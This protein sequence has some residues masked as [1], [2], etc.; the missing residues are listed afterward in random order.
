MNNIINQESWLPAFKEEKDHIYIL[1]T[2]LNL[3]GAEKIVSD[4]LWA[5]FYQ[6]APHKVT[7]FV[8]YDKNQE[9]SIP[10]NVNIVR[11]NNKIENGEM[12]LKQV[13]FDGKPLV[14][15]LINDK[16]SHYL[17]SLGLNLHIVIHNDKKGWSNTEEVFNHPQVISLISVCKYVTKQL[18]EVTDKT[19]FTVRHQ[20]SYKHFQFNP[21]TRDT[22]RNHFKFKNDDIVIGMTGRI[23]LQKNYFLALDVIAHLSRKDPRYKLVIL[24]GFEQSNMPVYFD[25]LKKANTLN[26]QKNITLPGFKDNAVEWLN[27]FDI[28]LN[29]SHFEGLSMATQEFIMNGLQMVVSNVSGQSEIF[30]N[31]KQLHFFDIPESLNN[32][33]TKN[34]SIDLTSDDV[35]YDKS[36]ELYEYKKLVEHI[37]MLIEENHSKRVTMNDENKN[38]INHITYGSHNVWSLFNFIPNKQKNKEIKPAFLTSNL[39]LGGA[40]RSLVNL[41]SEMKDNDIHIPLILL[42][43]SNYT[44]FYKQIID[45]KIEHYLCHSHIDVFTIGS[46]LLKYI[47]ENEINRI[48]LWNVD[49]KVKL[50]L[51][52]LAGH[53]VDI[54]DVSPGDYCFNEMDNQIAFQEAIYFNKET[55]FENIKT[56]VSKFDNSHL[57]QDYKK[58]LKQDTVII[59][60]GV[61]VMPEYVKTL[62]G[63]D[64][65]FKFLVCG[66]ITESKHI[67]TILQAFRKL[68]EVNKNVCIDFYGSVEPYNIS[69]YEKLCSDYSD[70]IKNEVVKFKGNIDDPRSIMKDYHSIIILGTH[71]GSPNMVLES[72]SCK[73]PCITND[74]GGTKEVINNETG[75]LLPEKPD[76]MLLHEA[77]S[78]TVY[79]YKTVS[80]R[81]ESAYEHIMENFSMKLM[82]ER[83]LKVIYS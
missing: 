24:G 30:D 4:Q 7:L 52:K 69:Y 47:F 37:A 11:L 64:G 35:D 14:C 75:I 32:I 72:A 10:P 17:F 53:Y 82:L 45:K 56:F 22:Y 59:P 34:L 12:L 49:S 78:F 76:A 81:A 8:I 58:H 73:L 43:Q 50:L 6:K 40:Q 79:N 2:S 5:N 74:S 46:N 63:V 70:L 9:H 67:E 83:Y 29:V 80:E 51:S 71:Q 27:M 68:Y 62:S 39:N 20:I 3:G 54:I 18:K 13:A 15:H 33:D 31:N 55:Y 36:Q 23:C 65:V 42:N 16:I 44:G 19:I 77:M 38:L 41:L 57:D 28:G 1:L 61:P 48:I 60:N 26:V 25:I 66:R 21:K